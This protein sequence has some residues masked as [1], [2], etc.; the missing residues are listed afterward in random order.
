MSHTPDPNPSDKQLE[1]YHYLIA[2]VSV[3]GFQPSLE[4]IG[5]V[6]GVTRNAIHGRMK[7]LQRRGYIELP[8]GNRERSVIFLNIQFEPFMANEAKPEPGAIQAKIEKF[9][10]EG[11]KTYID[12]RKTK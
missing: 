6:F 1:V 3:H 7:E 11:T 8:D 4:E 2:H 5:K 10:K 9:I 12:E